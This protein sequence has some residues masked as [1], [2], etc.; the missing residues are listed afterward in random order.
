MTMR[1]PPATAPVRRA[2]REGEAPAEPIR[3]AASTIPSAKS[4]GRISSAGASPSRP[5]GLAPTPRAGFTLIELLIVVV[6]VLLITAVAIPVIAP[7][8]QG[9][10][11]REASRE[12]STFLAVTRDRA[13]ATGRPCGIWIERVPDQPDV[14]FLISQCEVPPPF[15]GD[16]SQS[17]VAVGFVPR[18]GQNGAFPRPLVCLPL[19]YVG[20]QWSPVQGAWDN[21]IREGDLIKFNHQGHT[22]MLR[23]QTVAGMPMWTIGSWVS[24]ANNNGRADPWEVVFHENHSANLLMLP[25]RSNRSPP[26]HTFPFQITRQPKKSSGRALQLPGGMVLD[27]NYSGEIQL[28]TGAP[29]P[30]FARSGV[31]SGDAYQGAPLM[32][33]NEPTEIAILFAPNGSLEHVYAV[34][35]YDLIGGQY[36][37]LGGGT[38]Y[39]PTSPL[40]LLVGK[41]AN[42]PLY[43]SQVAL[44]LKLDED[45][46]NWLDPES[47][48]IAINPTTGLVSTSEN[49]PL[50][51][52]ID[53]PKNPAN[54]GNSNA[55]NGQIDA[56]EYAVTPYLQQARGFAVLSSSQGG[57]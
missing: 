6:I 25:P 54:S 38:C 28:G 37:P 42:V 56:N 27:L 51:A 10:R 4:V 46:P 40:Y 35:G 21:L 5:G 34:G 43:G 12:L 1:Q 44:P 19:E 16:S 36:L 52:W 32:L 39:Q 55:G 18:E 15:S 9:R 47:I 20:N 29:L 11:A 33:Q 26:E 53:D 50:G 45:L 3:R 14:A 24:D 41:R 48:W 17:R 31:T 23:Q 30:F 8:V 49:I 22:F 13:I 57:R 2:S 7:A